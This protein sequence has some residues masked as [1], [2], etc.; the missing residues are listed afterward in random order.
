MIKVIPG[1]DRGRWLRPS[2]KMAVYL[3]FEH[4]QA[5][6]VRVTLLP[7]GA[8]VEAVQGERGSQ[9][10]APRRLSTFVTPPGWWERLRGVTFEDKVLAEVAR[11]RLIAAHE[12]R[13]ARLP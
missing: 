6:G 9:Y 3:E 12:N 4:P 1:L 5:W 8:H 11:K 10:R 13:S 7:E 2:D